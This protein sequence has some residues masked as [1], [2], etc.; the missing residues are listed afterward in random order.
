MCQTG[1]DSVATIPNPGKDLAYD[2]AHYLV[3][4]AHSLA[5]WAHSPT[6]RPPA[7]LPRSGPHGGQTPPLTGGRRA[8]SP[9]PLPLFISDTPNAMS[10]GQARGKAT[11][12]VRFDFPG[13]R[14][15]K[16]VCA[17]PMMCPQDRFS[18]DWCGANHG[19]QIGRA[20]AAGRPSGCIGSGRRHHSARLYKT[21][22]GGS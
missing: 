2:P 20:R 11:A 22:C 14:S 6:T 19:G 1:P 18:I 21:V 17:V 4:W 5:H 13:C 9:P 3:H 16:E 10:G 15:R 7:G 8:I 12:G